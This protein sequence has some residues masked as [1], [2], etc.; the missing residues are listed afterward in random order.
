MSEQ[1]FA[2]ITVI[3]FGQ[4]IAVPYCAQLLADGGARVIKVEPHTGDPVRLLGPLAPGETRHFISRNRGKRVLPLDLRHAGSARILEALFSQADVALFNLRPGLGAELGLDFATLSPGYPRL[5][6]GNVTA[7]GAKGPDAGLAGM[8][9]VVQARSGLMTAMGRMLD[10][11]PAAG[12]TPIA[13]FM[14]AMTLAFGVSTAL[15]RRESINI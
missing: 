10:G 15:Y 11:M 14:C 12:D 4:F 5:I 6:T 8:D 13:D 3:E 1:P 9:L 2:G 7:F